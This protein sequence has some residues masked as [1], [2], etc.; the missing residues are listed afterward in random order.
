MLILSA[1]ISL[2][3]LQQ[4]STHDQA[5]PPPRNFQHI[6]TRSDGTALLITECI[7]IPVSRCF[8]YEYNIKESTIRPLPVDDQD[9][10]SAEYEGND[11]VISQYSPKT[12]QSTVSQLD[13]T[14]KISTLF[15]TPGM[16]R[17]PRR[18]P[19]NSF[20]YLKNQISSYGQM[21]CDV[22]EH[23]LEGEGEHY[24]SSQFSFFSCGTFSVRP[25]GSLLLS[26]EGPA[27]I[28]DIGAYWKKNNRS[29]IYSLRRNAQQLPPPIFTDIEG[30]RLP[31]I[32][33]E[34]SVF[35]S[36]QDKNGIHIFKYS[37]DGRQI[38]KHRIPPSIGGIL[39]IS[40]IS[41]QNTLYTIAQPS[42]YGRNEYI[43]AQLDTNKSEWMPIKIPPFP[44]HR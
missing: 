18:T 36:G 21:R 42:N 40:N 30:A 5:P 6:S 39:Y 17:S 44:Q 32:T 38:S 31:S 20:I 33:K 43:I 4:V 37:A 9:V 25:D 7:K 14:S 10:I 12:K 1:L 26:A 28:T 16:A 15:I 29:E 24:F 8:A 35:I 34:G 19:A 27:A 41:Q 11:I 23:P 3:G 22:M 2:T 13:T